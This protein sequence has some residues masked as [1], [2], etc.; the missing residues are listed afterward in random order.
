LPT[1]SDIPALVT[2][3]YAEFIIG[4]AFA[5]PVGWSALLACG[6]R[7]L[8]QAIP[9]QAILAINRFR[10]PRA[11]LRAPARSVK[12]AGEFRSAHGTGEASSG[13]HF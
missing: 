3:D 2:A 10:Q 12:A 7:H 9:A 5:R 1:R 6:R 8:P 11:F 13:R 4:R